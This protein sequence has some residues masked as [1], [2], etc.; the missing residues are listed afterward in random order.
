[1]LLATYVVGL[2][3]LP[4]NLLT[5][6]NWLAAVAALRG[7]TAGN[8]SL[9]LSI[10]LPL[11]PSLSLT[12]SVHAKMCRSQTLCCL[13]A[14]PLHLPFITKYWPSLE[15]TALLE[16]VANLLRH[17][18]CC[19]SAVVVVG[20]VAFGSRPINFRIS[21]TNLAINF[22]AVCISSTL[23]PDLLAQVIHA[24]ANAN[25]QPTSSISCQRHRRHLQRQHHFGLTRMAQALSR[26]L[27]KAPL[28]TDKSFC[29]LACARIWPTTDNANGQNDSGPEPRHESANAHNGNLNMRWLFGRHFAFF[30][31]LS[32]KCQKATDSVFYLLKFTK[33]LHT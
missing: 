15:P 33:L 8:D 20:V 30:L 9:S 19:L 5:P 32:F 10:P 22:Y 27:I 18:L 11:S 25:R 6:W 16:F 29:K 14:W 28:A 24:N 12:L 1:M 21:Q 31:F 7:T 3:M 4:I 26:Q 17:K 23:L 2:L 13:V